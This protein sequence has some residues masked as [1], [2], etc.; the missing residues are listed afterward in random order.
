[1]GGPG[2]S[3]LA[4]LER[5]PERRRAREDELSERARAPPGSVL[6][7]LSGIARRGMDPMDWSEVGIL[8]GRRVRYPFRRSGFWQAV[9]VRPP[10]HWPVS[11]YADR[12]YEARARALVRRDPI[13][14][15]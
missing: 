12:R 8:E 11:V 1:L 6:I 4:R 2:G 7:D 5:D 13:L 9:T 14:G 3:E 15:G 10:S